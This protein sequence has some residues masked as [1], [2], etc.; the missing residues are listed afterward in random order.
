M[1]KLYRFLYDKDSVITFIEN[2]EQGITYTTSRVLIDTLEDAVEYF[3]SKAINI[4]VI[5]ESGLYQ[6]KNPS[7]IVEKIIPIDN[8]GNKRKVFINKLPINFDEKR[9]TLICTVKHYDYH[10]DE[11]KLEYDYIKEFKTTEDSTIIIDGVEVNEFD[12]YLEKINENGLEK[13]L[14]FAVDYLYSMGKL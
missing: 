8:H 6:K 4:D 11:E 1:E 7:V 5:T 14:K 12:F 9:F 2:E 10:T 3:I 13:T